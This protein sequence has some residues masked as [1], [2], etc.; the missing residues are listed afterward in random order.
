[1]THS[2]DLRRRARIPSPDAHNL[3]QLK[4]LAD[5]LHY[6]ATRSRSPDDGERRAAAHEQALLWA[7]RKLEG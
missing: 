5:E 1:M 2:V 4:R 6:R 7:I 3:A